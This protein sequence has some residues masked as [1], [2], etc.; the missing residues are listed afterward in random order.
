LEN[1]F[2]TQGDRGKVELK[3]IG[4]IIMNLEIFGENFTILG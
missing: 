1:K 3:I 4:V 2:L